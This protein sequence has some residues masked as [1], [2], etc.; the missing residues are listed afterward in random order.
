M[1][2]SITFTKDTATV[3]NIKAAIKNCER[4]GNFKFAESLENAVKEAKKLNRI[5]TGFYNDCAFIVNYYKESKQADV[6]LLQTDGDLESLPTIHL[7]HMLRVKPR[8]VLLD[9]LKLV[10]S[11]DEHAT[12]SYDCQ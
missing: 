2:Q 4:T 6:A 5:V 1:N 11:D 3:M 10:G 12:L 8:E 9:V 7:Q